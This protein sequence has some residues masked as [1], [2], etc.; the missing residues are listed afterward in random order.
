MRRKENRSGELCGDIRLEARHAEDHPLRAT[1][2]LV[3][4]ALGRLA[5]R[6]AD[7]SWRTGRPSP[8]SATKLK[9][10]KYNQ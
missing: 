7:L 8:A 3:D 4:S 5:A 10:V 1:R 9:V 2:T 6:F